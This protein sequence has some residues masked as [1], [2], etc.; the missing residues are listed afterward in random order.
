MSSI[1]EKRITANLNSW[2]RV[3]GILVNS[4]ICYQALLYSNHS[5]PR[6]W[7][8]MPS[9]LLGPFNALYYSK[10]EWHVF[11]P[12]D[13]IKPFDGEVRCGEF[14]VETNCTTPF[15]GCG[16]Y[17]EPLV[18]YGLDKGYISHADI[19]LQLIPSP[20]LLRFCFSSLLLPYLGS[21]IK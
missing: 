4:F 15:R 7:I 8:C 18:Q 5:L 11:S 13:E 9:V 20:L 16:W 12:M 10:Y 3:P 6:W 21:G 17:S 19:R 2:V 14:Y 1:K